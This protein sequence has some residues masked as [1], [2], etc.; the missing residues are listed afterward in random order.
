MVD[1]LVWSLH[2]VR[3]PQDEMIGLF[4]EDFANVVQPRRDVSRS[5]DDTGRPIE[6]EH[7]G[8][9]TLEPSPVRNEL[10]LD[11][12]WLAWR[13]CHLI[14]GCVPIEP[15]GRGNRLSIRLGDRRNASVHT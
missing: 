2:P 14:D 5:R 11:E 3:E 1:L 8:P 10:I 9:W 15:R 13:P 7:R 6:V 4:R 12:H